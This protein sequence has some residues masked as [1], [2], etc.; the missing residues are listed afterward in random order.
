MIQVGDLVVISATDNRP[1]KQGLVVGF[2]KKGEGGKD[3]VHVLVD[4]TVE[5]FLRFV[6]DIINE[7]S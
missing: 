5:V 2:N 7:A 1:E 6:V 3:Y 4:G